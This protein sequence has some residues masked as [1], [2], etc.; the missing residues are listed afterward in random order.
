MKKEQI[1]VE[2]MCR[3]VAKVKEKISEG[4]G[5]KGI[6]EAMSDAL[7]NAAWDIYN[8]IV[9]K[10]YNSKIDTVEELKG[11]LDEML[12][13]VEKRKGIVVVRKELERN[14]QLDSEKIQMWGNRVSTEITRVGPVMPHTLTETFIT[15]LRKKK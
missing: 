4:R 15:G 10:K 11:L 5:V 12:K 14:G 13:G 1:T 7:M 8:D 2:E 3:F 9:T 6:R